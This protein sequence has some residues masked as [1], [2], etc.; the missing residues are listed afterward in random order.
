MKRAGRYWVPDVDNHFAPLFER[1]EEFQMDRLETALD[2]VEDFTTALDCGAHVGS[3]SIRM[4]KEFNAVYAFEPSRETFACLDRNTSNR[5]NV[6]A[7]NVA[8][9]DRPGFVSMCVDDTRGEGNTGAYFIKPINGENGG[10]DTVRMMTIDSL[11]FDHGVGFIKL[12]VEGAELLALRG[13]VQTIK[14]NKPVIFLEAKKKMGERFG[15]KLEAPLKYL[16]GLG[17]RCAKQI[18]NDYIFVF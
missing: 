3:W 10:L 9:G 13:A 6:F 12:D 1:G 16:E 15:F 14:A 7:L 17:A 18:V 8:V 11:G 4:A 5:S 2:Y